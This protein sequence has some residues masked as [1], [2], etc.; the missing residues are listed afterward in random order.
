MK[1]LTNKVYATAENNWFSP[2][3]EFH[4]KHKSILRMVYMDMTSSSGDWSGF[5]VQKTG[6]RKAH[7]IGFEQVNNYPHAGFTLYTCEH[8]FY[9]GDPTKPH[10]LENAQSC[11]LQ[12]TIPE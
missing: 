8:P 7:C 10:F 6:K 11:Y 4:E 3:C 2:A 9:T 1:L 12:F 5:V